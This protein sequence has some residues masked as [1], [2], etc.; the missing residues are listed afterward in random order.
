VLS[1]WLARQSVRL[2]RYRQ[3]LADVRMAQTIDM[4]MVS[5]LLREL[6]GMG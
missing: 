3:L 6:R 2:E 4:A 1:A 5:V